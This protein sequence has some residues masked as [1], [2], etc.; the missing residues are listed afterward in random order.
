VEGEARPG[1]M[2]RVRISRALEYDLVGVPLRSATTPFSLQ[3]V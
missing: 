1:D 2:L 3:I